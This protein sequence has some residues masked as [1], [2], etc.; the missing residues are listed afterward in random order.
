MQVPEHKDAVVVGDGGGAA[1]SA[2]YE[3]Y[4]SG[5]SAAVVLEPCQVSRW[6]G[7][8]GRV[9]HA[10]MEGREVRD[11]AGRYGGRGRRGCPPLDV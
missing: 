3:G 7:E 11:G 4:V 6:E 10:V 8:E 5:E 9:R 1:E 2:G